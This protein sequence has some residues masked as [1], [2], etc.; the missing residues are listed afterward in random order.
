MPPNPQGEREKSEFV[1][2]G[3]IL[4]TCK[5]PDSLL[6]RDRRHV[7]ILIHPDHTSGYHFVNQDMHRTLYYRLQVFEQLRESTQHYIEA[8]ILT[9]LVHV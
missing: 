6:E 9:T 2:S 5:L 1:P 8:S 4:C 3:K 7:N